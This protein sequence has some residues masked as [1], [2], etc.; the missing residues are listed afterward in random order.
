M[1]EQGVF[2][3]VYAGW[4]TSNWSGAVS[5]GAPT[6]RCQQLGRLGSRA[7]T[8]QPECLSP[9]AGGIQIV[10]IHFVLAGFYPD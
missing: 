9:A 8:G 1:C 2:T 4:S 3:C 5:S 7:A 6:S 10:Y